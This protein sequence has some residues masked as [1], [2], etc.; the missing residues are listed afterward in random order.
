MM[1]LKD[2]AHE[3]RN[4]ALLHK[5]NENVM[6]LLNHMRSI[7]VVNTPAQSHLPSPAG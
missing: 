2:E 5:I 3:M 4:V 6:T 7:L 1:M